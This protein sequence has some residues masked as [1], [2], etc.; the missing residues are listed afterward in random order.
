MKSEFW[1][2]FGISILIFSLLFFI[3]IIFYIRYLKKNKKF[4]V[5]TLD[6]LKSNDIESQLPKEKSSSGEKECKRVLEKLFKQEF[7]KER[8]DFLKNTITSTN[9]VSYNLEL[10]CYSKDLKLAVEYNG[11]Q[12]YEYIPFFHKN[13]ESFYNQK[14]RDEL[15]RIKCKENGIILI[16]VPYTIP[17]VKIEEYLIQMLK[18]MKIKNI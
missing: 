8:P 5:L 18:S 13:K 11:K 15:K 14:Y 17:I 6:K 7:K 16:E 1:E 4:S 3:A 10:D 9:K 2:N 12:H